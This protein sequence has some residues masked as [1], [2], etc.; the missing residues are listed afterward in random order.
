MLGADVEVIWFGSWP[1]GTAN[2]HADI[3]IAVSGPT[4]FL[5]ERL[6]ELRAEIEDMATLHEI[7]VVDLRTVGERFKQEILCH[8]I[9]L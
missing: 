2:A 3:D 5:P 9:H 8:G 1:K 7:D 4:A 6:A